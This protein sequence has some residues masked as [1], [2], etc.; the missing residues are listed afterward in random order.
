VSGL[1]SFRN[2]LKFI[3]DGNYSAA[4]RGMLASKW[5]GQV[6]GRANKLATQLDT[7]EWQ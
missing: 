4:A 7:G 5:A 6:K 2:T 1:L 3:E